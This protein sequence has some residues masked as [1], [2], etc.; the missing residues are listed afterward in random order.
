MNDTAPG[1]L[2][3]RALL[4]DAWH[5]VRDRSAAAGVDG[6]SPDV[7]GLDLA[8]QVNA[9]LGDLA[10]GVYTPQACR[11]VDIP[12]TGGGHRRV[13]IPTV[14]DRVAQAAACALLQPHIEPLLHPCSYAYRAGVG[15]HDALLKVA[16][17][18]NRGLVHVLR[19]DIAR[20][21]DTVRHDLLLR[22]LELAEVPGPLR[23][24]VS[25]WITG[26]IAAPGEPALPNP[27]GLPQGLPVSPLLAN[28]Y[29]TPFDRRIVEAGW[30]LVRY[31]DDFT[32]CC[33]APE[34]AET[35]RAECAAALDPLGLTL[36]PDKTHTASFEAGFEYLGARFQGGDVVP[37]VAHPYEADF[38]PPPRAPR[39]PP[40]QTAPAQ[41][42]RTLYL[43]QQGSTLGCHGGR[44][45][46][47][48]AEKTLLDL[49][50]RHVD[51]VFI[52][53][54]VHIT[55]PAMQFCLR[56]GI[57]VHLFSGRGRYCGVLRRF[58]DPDYALRRAQFL[59][60]EDP[61]RRLAF[62]RA[63]VA[64]KV[65]NARALYMRQ[66]RNHPSAE[67]DTFLDGLAGVSERVAACDDMD[68]LRGVEGAAAAVAWRAFGACLRGSLPFTHRSR[69]PP[70]D[71][72]N[73]LLSF[74]Y[75]LLF[76]NAYGVLTARGLDTSM[77]LFHEPGRGHPALVSDLVEEFRA[78][79]VEALVLSV[80]NAGRFGPEDFYHDD[81][82][83][84]A[85]LLKDDAR[86]R[87][88]AAFEEKMAALRSHPDAP[89]PV[90]WRTIIDLQARRLRRFVEGVVA[91]YRPFLTEK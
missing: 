1:S 25:A 50:A 77:G 85:C 69:R 81:G 80:V 65:A 51:Q 91:D 16:E 72:V 86:A 63:V 66:A 19:A 62:A 44:L 61:V 55:T 82:E 83:P 60:R 12:K 3:T 52:F 22:Q 58:S 73:S 79:V 74:G 28:L 36:A 56:S 90:E 57:P 5:R 27:L 39:R 43:Q 15:V 26:L 71:P 67:L 48:R 76:H 4:E 40:S 7:F 78:P 31:A 14:R 64:A 87:Y 45:V 70:A 46:V 34:D 35:A 47:S 13:V 84:R 17:Y 20:F 21:F 18:R 54:R 6:V 42:L 9:L 68:Q 49:H 10:A 30:K 59:L 33:G 32:V 29:L 2:F 11:A 41:I 88:L 89:H 23:A 24:L 53:G 38:A 8:A 37:A 75:A